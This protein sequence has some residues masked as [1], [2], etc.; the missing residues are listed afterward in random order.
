MT[1]TRGTEQPGDATPLIN[2]GLYSLGQLTSYPSG[3]QELINAVTVNGYNNNF[4]INVNFPFDW[5]STHPV[6]AS[7]NDASARSAA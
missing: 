4:S 1:Y 5:T 2:D 6:A 7:A 3:V